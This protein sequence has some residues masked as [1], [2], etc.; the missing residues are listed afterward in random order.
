MGQSSYGMKTQ[1]QMVSLC[2]VLAYGYATAPGT[3]QSD[4]GILQDCM[5]GPGTPADPN[6]AAN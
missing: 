2:M 4:F 1:F 3:D 5:S 6:C